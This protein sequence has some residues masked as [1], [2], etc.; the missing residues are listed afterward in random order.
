M[1][2]LG[3]SVG[4]GT[5]GFSHE[6]NAT[7]S[8]P[9]PGRSPKRSAAVTTLVSGAPR[10]DGR[11]NNTGAVFFLPFKHDDSDEY[12]MTLT[13][14]RYRLVGDALLGSS[15]GY[16][17]AVVDINQDGFDDLVVGAPN[18]FNATND[19]ENSGAVYVYFSKGKQS[20]FSEVF[21]SPVRILGPPGKDVQFGASIANLG[22]LNKDGFHGKK[23]FCCFFFNFS[24]SIFVY[25]FRCRRALL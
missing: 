3:F 11:E 12:R 22:D 25:R 20:E 19:E 18:F 7:Q 2:I 14:D 9:A 24:A 17:L 5:F 8:T 21:H 16:S 10:Y 15:F 4:V 13:P 6:K 23:A 1:G